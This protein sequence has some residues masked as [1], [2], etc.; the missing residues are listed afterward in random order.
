MISLAR[1]PR[2]IPKVMNALS[3]L[4][5]RHPD[6][7]LCQLITN[8]G[9]E[10]DTFYVEDDELLERIMKKLQDGWKHEEVQHENSKY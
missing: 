6:L 4:W 8:L 5:A 2:R 3:V 7:R 9:E 10:D 1:D